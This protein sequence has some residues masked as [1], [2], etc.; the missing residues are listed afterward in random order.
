MIYSI[1]ENHVMDSLLKKSEGLM[2]ANPKQSAYYAKNVLSMIE[3]SGGNRLF[4]VKS[5]I[6]YGNANQLQGDFDLAIK[7]YHEALGYITTED[8]VLLAVVQV[9]L[10]NIY[11]TLRD[12]PKAF[13]F[14]EN[15][16][17][18]YKSLGDSIGLATC[19]NSQGIIHCNLHEYEASEQF[20]LSAA[21]INRKLN[22]MKA[23][24]GNLNNMALYEGD[25]K[26]KIGN[27][28]EAIAINK[29]L[30]AIWALAENYNNLGRQYFYS[31]QYEKAATSL[32]V[33]EMYAQKIG[34]KELVCDN[35]EYKSHLY[36]AQK[37]YAKAY[38]HLLKL[39]ELQ[40]S[41]QSTKNLRNI[42]REISERKF[43]LKKKELEISE[44]THE[45]ELLR[46]NILV[47]I[48]ALVSLVVLTVLGR[49]W[50]RRKRV[51]QLMESNFELEQ[52]N[53]KIAELQIKQ[54]QVE[55]NDIE[56]ELLGSK[57][58][59]T[60]F[61][62]YLKSRNEL[63]EKIKELIKQGCKLDKLMI[64]DHLKK[65]NVFISQ[66]QSGKLESSVIFESIEHKNKEYIQRLMQVHP[67]LTQVEKKLAILL[68]VNFSTKDISLL[69][70]VQPKTI[71]MN[72]Y[73]LR[74]KIG[75]NS[76][77]DLTS[78]LQSI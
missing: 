74:K 55:I 1:D 78:Y 24:A 6:A 20:F 48:I 15:A 27:L 39:Q 63:L 77:E 21:K 35:Y 68:R 62:M 40:L 8:E 22:E 57:R 4:R 34:A 31:L 26:Q 44:K 28:K 7:N 59:L 66:Y 18:L 54:Q 46:K 61:A 56:Q 65:I 14:I 13:D 47:L 76:E 30:N 45:I 2:Y 11:C 29:S 5:L 38:E 37:Q 73:R 49:K 71:N 32:N 72:R 16:T 12:F 42:E 33:A 50:Y 36:A 58:E 60:N 70:G 43:F 25:A 19:Y 69:T 67:D 52:S 9:R 41:L 17:A 64:V 51:L 23:L 53:R 10:S 3:Q 75:L